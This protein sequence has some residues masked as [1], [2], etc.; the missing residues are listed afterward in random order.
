MPYDAK[1]GPK[2]ASPTPQIC[3][4]TSG[5]VRVAWEAPRE[6]T[7]MTEEERELWALRREEAIHG[8]FRRLFPLTA[9][10]YLRGEMGMTP[11]LGAWR[12]SRRRD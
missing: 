12:R 5:S 10:R 3:D 11:R 8:L 7:A 6:L 1:T 2:G 4:A 9:E